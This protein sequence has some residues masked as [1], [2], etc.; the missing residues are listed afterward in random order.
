MKQSPK[1][2]RIIKNRSVFKLSLM[3]WRDDLLVDPNGIQTTQLSFIYNSFQNKQCSKVCKYVAYLIS[4]GS[5]LHRIMTKCSRLF[6]STSLLF[7]QL[8]ALT[9]VLIKFVPL[10][11]LFKFNSSQV[12]FVSKC[13]ITY[14]YV[15][16]YIYEIHIRT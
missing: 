16:N 3:I 12:N 1:R 5:C 13:G 11:N 4:I 9:K 8:I 14:L 6:K 15:I 2:Q 7:L 10:L